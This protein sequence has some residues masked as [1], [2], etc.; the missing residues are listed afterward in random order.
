VRVH[1]KKTGERRYGIFVERED[2]HDVYMNPAPGFDEYLPHDLLHFVAESE[3]GIDDAVFGQLAAGGDAATFIP[4]IPVGDVPNKFKHRSARLMK[5][6]ANM[7]RSEDLAS[8]LHV[9]WARRHGRPEVAHRGRVVEVLAAEATAI[10]RLA[11]KID[12]LA[13]RWNA[14]RVGESLTFEWP[15][16]PR[17]SSASRA[18]RRAVGGTR[19]RSGGRARA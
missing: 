6:A 7:G 5:A 1:F 12:E 4:A 14:L 10:E 18:S 15:L 16:R 3:W 2:A 11:P 13:Q 8:A 9:D 19:A 17:R